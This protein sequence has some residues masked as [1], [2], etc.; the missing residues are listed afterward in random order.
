MKLNSYNR[1][2]IHER[3][4]SV[5]LVCVWGGTEDIT[6]KIRAMLHSKYNIYAHAWD[7]GFNKEKKLTI[8][9]VMVDPENASKARLILLSE[10]Y[11]AYG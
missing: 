6:D 7:V 9:Q 5:Q 3:E 11:D 8:K 2:E 10:G 4:R 1:D